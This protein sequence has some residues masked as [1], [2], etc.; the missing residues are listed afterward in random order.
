MSVIDDGLSLLREEGPRG[1]LAGIGRHLRWSLG[2]YSVWVRSRI[3][4]S[5]G[6]VRLSAADTTA[7]FVAT[8]AGSIGATLRR[9]RGEYDRLVAVL[10]DLEGDDVFYDI[11]A[12]TG[13]YTCFAAKNCS[14][15]VAFEPYPPN[16]AEL[17]RNVALNGL[18]ASVHEVAL[19]DRSGTIGFSTE[20]DGGLND[21]GSGGAG[22]GR[23]T[24]TDA[25]S[26]L[27]VPAVRGDELI[28]AGT[29][30]R[31][32]ILKIDVEGAESLVIDGLSEALSAEA[33]RVVYCEVHEPGASRGPDHDHTV[34]RSALFET[35]RELGFDAV[36]ALDTDRHEFVI[37]AEKTNV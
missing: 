30:P 2:Q 22:F 33:C 12:N 25:G 1:L 6:Q 29:I 23:G 10:A 5:R 35:F 3:A 31:P 20:G 21:P 8:N 16:V 28:Q 27:E 26:D 9:H 13:L 32:N 34:D 14:Q 11:G 36:E 19:S 15:V 24:I 7:A 37:R 17:K 4:T 18:D